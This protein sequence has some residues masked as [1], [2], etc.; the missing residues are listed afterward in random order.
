VNKVYGTRIL[1]HEQTQKYAGDFIETREID[2]IQVV[3]KDEPVRIF[4]LIGKK[5]EVD[6]KILKLR[7]QFE[8]GLQA[9]RNQDWSQAGQLFNDCLLKNLMIPHH[10]CF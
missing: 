1:I 3:G 5:T 7:N 2:S 8:K 10:R 6:E 9:Y 4:E